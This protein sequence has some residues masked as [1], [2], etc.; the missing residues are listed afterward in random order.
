MSPH[1]RKTNSLRP[2]GNLVKKMLYSYKTDIIN[3]LFVM[4]AFKYEVADSCIDWFWQHLMNVV[5]D[6][7]V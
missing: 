6:L 5:L 7:V 1:Q 4:V 3:L 2:D